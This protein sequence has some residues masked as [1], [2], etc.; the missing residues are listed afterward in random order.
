TAKA[1]DVKYQYYHSPGG[2]DAG[3]IHVSNDGV[4]SAVVGICSRYIHTANSIINYEDYFHA[5]NLLTS[6]I[7]NVNNETVDRIRG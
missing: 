1:S 4:P 2:T 3:S 7:K 5:H 6:L